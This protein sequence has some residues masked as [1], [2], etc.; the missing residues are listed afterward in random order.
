MST[1][2]ATGAADH[3]DGGKV[4]PRNATSIITA[5]ATI[6]GSSSIFAPMISRDSAGEGTGGN[7]ASHAQM[8]CAKAVKSNIAGGQNLMRVPSTA[9]ARNPVVGQT[10]L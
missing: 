1:A 9:M 8:T 4:M 7:A 2:P 5:A 6:A 10:R 3:I